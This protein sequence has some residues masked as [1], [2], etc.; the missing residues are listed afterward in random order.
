MSDHKKTGPPDEC[1][2]GGRKESRSDEW[3]MNEIKLG[4]REYLEPLIRRHGGSLLSYLVR[5]TKNRDLAEEIFQETFLKVW[6]RRRSYKHPLLFRPWLY[7]IAVNQ[8]RQEYRR[9]ARRGESVD[10]GIAGDQLTTDQSQLDRVIAKETG[11]RAIMATSRLPEKQREVLHLRIWNN[12]SYE[13]IASI[14]GCAEATA[15]AN[16]HHAL[17]SLRKIMATN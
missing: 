10:G 12:F 13:E 3:L 16:M 4:R 5:T 1:P 17:K 6:Q 9:R 14:L 8:L 15:R 7:T 11:E 2:D